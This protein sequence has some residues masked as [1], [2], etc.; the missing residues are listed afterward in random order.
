MRLNHVFSQLN[1]A[2]RNN[3]RW[4]SAGL[5]FCLSW[6]LSACSNSLID[7]TTSSSAE[8]VVPASQI[9]Q[10]NWQ[11]FEIFPELKAVPV[12]FVR[13]VD[14]DTIKVRLNHHSFRVRYLM[15]DTPE[16][17]KEG[18][19]VQPFGFES[20][21]R[22]EELLSQAKQIYLKFDYGQRVDDYQR[23]LA[24]VYADQVLVP[25]Q[26]L[27]E[28]LASVSYIHPPANSFE[29]EFRQAQAKAKASNLGVWSIPGYVNERGKFKQQY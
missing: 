7:S 19:K 28:G 10:F 4:Y 5:I 29:T 8:D 1:R 16:S 11:N 25:K 22:N 27:L 20:Y 23:V 3:K 9:S 26:L 17:K 6:S 2:I 13:V 21:Q 14:G 12:E 24:Y 18:V 15:I